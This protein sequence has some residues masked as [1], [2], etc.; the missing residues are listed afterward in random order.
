M[1]C[2]VKSVIPRTWKSKNMKKNVVQYM[3][4]KLVRIIFGIWII[5]Q[6]T[7]I[8]SNVKDIDNRL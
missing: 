3:V 6:R 4:P 2:G 5:A 8:I 7:H 1:Y